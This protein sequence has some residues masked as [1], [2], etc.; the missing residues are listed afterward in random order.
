M[1][2]NDR[3]IDNT[4]SV[5]QQT[6]NR[7]PRRLERERRTRDGLA[8]KRDAARLSPPSDANMRV[9]THKTDLHPRE[10]GG[11]TYTHDT[12]FFIP[13]SVCGL[14]NPPI[15]PRGGPPS[16]LLPHVPHLRWVVSVRCFTRARAASR[17]GRSSPRRKSD[18]HGGLEVEKLRHACW[19]CGRLARRRKVQRYEPVQNEYCAK[20]A[21]VRG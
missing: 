19:R 1:R 13:K 14:T 11:E 3:T 15:G 16:A 6:G 5:V 20:A 7:R 12:F 17:T 21:T 8:A 9:G 2:S 10:R 4:S 18:G